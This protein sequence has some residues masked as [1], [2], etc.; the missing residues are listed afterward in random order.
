M[1]KNNKLNELLTSHNVDTLNTTDTF[2]PKSGK[3][4]EF[5]VVRN[6]DQCIRCLA[7]VQ[8]CA[9]EAN[10]FHK[11]DFKI[12]SDDSLCVGCHR[13]EVMCPTDAITIEKTDQ[14]KPNANWSPTHIRALY[15]QRDT[16]GILITG[17]GNDQPFPI[18]WDHMLFDA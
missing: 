13:C 3:F 11:T 8:Q 15:K 4:H 18:Y 12:V 1:L 14:F 5:K 6:D 16:G 7:C 2:T 17:M 9:F 10:I